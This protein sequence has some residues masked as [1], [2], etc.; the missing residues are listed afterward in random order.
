MK[1]IVNARVIELSNRFFELNNAERA[2]L[3]RLKDN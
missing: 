2:E 1:M 3:M